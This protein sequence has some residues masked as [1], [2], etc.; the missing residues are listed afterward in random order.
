VALL[1]RHAAILSR[2]GAGEDPVPARLQADL[3]AL[4]SLSRR[5][6]IARQERLG[7]ALISNPA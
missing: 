6:L 4:F 1:G 7:A 2:T 3:T 5:R